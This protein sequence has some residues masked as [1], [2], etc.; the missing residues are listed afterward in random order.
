MFQF[1]QSIN[2][3]SLMYG[4]PH[5][6]LLHHFCQKCRLVDGSEKKTFFHHILEK[7]I[8]LSFRHIVQQKLPTRLTYQCQNKMIIIS[9]LDQV[10]GSPTTQ[11]LTL[12]TQFGCPSCINQKKYCMLSLCYIRMPKFEKHFCIDI[13]YDK[14]Q[15]LTNKSEKCEPSYSDL[16]RR[17]T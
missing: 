6:H 5:L 4:P 17:R 16:M 1:A 9:S 12:T 10:Q 7:I 11:I 14:S 3:S 15:R 8:W 2:F 13:E